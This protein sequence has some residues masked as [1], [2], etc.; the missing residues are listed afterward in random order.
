MIKPRNLII[1]AVVLA[2]LVAVS[3]WQKSSHDKTTSRSSTEMVISGALV[4]EDLGRITAGFGENQEA[5]VLEKQPD[6]WVVA[7]AWNSPANSER[8]DTLLRNLSNLHGEFRSDSDA[9]LADYGLTDNTA[10]TV[11]GYATDG[12]DAF[13]LDI[14]KSPERSPGNFMRSPGQSKVYVSTQGLLS[15]L[16]LY[17][18]PEAPNSKHFLQLEVV[19][20]DRQ[21]VD[22]I[23]LQDGDVTIELVKE[24]SV[25]EPA[26]EGAEP[27]IDRTVWEWKMRQPQSTAAVKTKADAVLGAL[28]SLRAT[29]VDDPTVAGSN[30]GLDAPA[31][32]ATVNFND[33]RQIVLA[34]GGQRAQQDDVSGGIWM[35]KAGDP[36][37]WVVTDYSLTN[38]FKTVE[39]LLPTAE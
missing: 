8:I 18:E 9:V 38:I 6:G 34:F 35:Q 10:V 5:V 20:E 36:T 27:T 2:A 13:G 4:K 30:Y 17:G 7:S 28:V 31:R 11:R 19:K 25:T 14:G 22:G 15:H 1:M 23:T 26:E 12:S 37:V 3:L 33:G 16:G 39:D 29:D 21:A 32:T 24:F